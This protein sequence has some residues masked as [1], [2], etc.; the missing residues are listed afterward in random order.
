MHPNATT[1]R[2]L[3]ARRPV[4][5]APMEDVTDLV[6]RR[7]CR[8]VGAELC[9]TEFVNVEGLLRGCRKAK[10][11]LHLPADDVPTVIQI[12]GRRGRRAFGPAGHRHQLRL[13]GAQ[14]RRSRRRRGLA[15]G[16]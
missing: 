11:K 10:R 9:V 7:L 12:Y 2:G 15:A 13:L 3:Y 16:P 4:I 14:D 1:L 6:F 5:L 8:E